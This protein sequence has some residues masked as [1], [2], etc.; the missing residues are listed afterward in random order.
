MPETSWE[1]G[2]EESSSDTVLGG[3]TS[4]SMHAV[5]ACY[6]ILREAN[7]NNFDTYSTAV[8]F[9]LLQHCCRRQEAE[10]LLRSSLQRSYPT[11]REHWGLL[12]LLQ[13]SATDQSPSR[14]VK[15]GLLPRQPGGTLTCC[16]ST[17]CSVSLPECSQRMAR[18]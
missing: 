15:S 9:D 4:C 8:A 12:G 5:S 18:V 2:K 1:G 7:S 14:M 16:L 3:F 13:V 10:R 17:R 11:H 6:A